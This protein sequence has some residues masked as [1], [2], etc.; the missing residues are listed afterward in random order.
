MICIESW[1]LPVFPW[2][3]FSLPKQRPRKTNHWFYHIHLMTQ[4]WCSYQPLPTNTFTI[5]SQLGSPYSTTLRQRILA[6]K[7]DRCVS[8]ENKPRSGQTAPRRLCGY[9]ILSC[10][11]LRFPLHCVKVV[12]KKY[13][14]CSSEVLQGSQS[15]LNILCLVIPG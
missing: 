10:V 8:Q 12:I 4:N 3:F 13:G 5:V 9:S 6:K 11:W 14:L 2:L 1:V 7:L 15:M